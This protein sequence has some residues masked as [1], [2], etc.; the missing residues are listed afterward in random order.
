MFVNDAAGRTTGAQTC[1]ACHGDPFLTSTNTPNTGM[2]APTFRGARDRWMVLPQGRVNLIDLLRPV[3]LGN[4]FVERDLW[5]LIGLTPDM[6]QMTLEGS[7]GLSGSFARQ[8]T[9]NAGPV[10]LPLTARVLDA[11]ERS[12]MA[13]PAA[14]T[15]SRCRTP[16]ASSATT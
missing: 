1:A 7:T 3:G 8:V 2:E 4:G 14:C 13:S 15:S 10:R 5:I 11:L 6:W 16:R 9:L 12:A